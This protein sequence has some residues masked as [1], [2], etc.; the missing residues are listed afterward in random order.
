MVLLSLSLAV[1]G[2]WRERGPHQLSLVAAIGYATRD[3]SS[4]V[5]YNEVL[6]V[7]REGWTKLERVLVGFTTLLMTTDKI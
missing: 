4:G 7:N 5:P 3:W 6:P 2:V 1:L